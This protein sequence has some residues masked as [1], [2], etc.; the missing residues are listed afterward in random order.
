MYK[1]SIAKRVLALMGVLVVSSSVLAAE[2]RDLGDAS[3]V[4]VYKSTDEAELKLYIYNPSDHRADDARGAM[5]FFHGGGW[6]SGSPDQFAPHCRLLASQGMVAITAEYR[7]IQKHKTPAW[8]CVEDAKSAMRWVRSHA[9]ALGIDPERI[10]VG[11]GS[12][13]GHLA[14]CIGLDVPGFDSEGEDTSVRASADAMVLFNPALNIADIPKNYRWEGRNTDASPLQLVAKG[15]PPTIIFHGK[16]DQ[17]VNYDQAEAFEQ[18][19]KSAD[20]DCR[21]MGFE[22]AEHGFFNFGRG[23]GSAYTATTTA[24]VS[25]LSDL[26]FITPT[27]P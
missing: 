9:V 1:T 27:A 25:F 24:M 8:R 2:G 14:A 3:E 19:M 4:R 12:A 20:N 13:G 7:L 17:T 5:I 6:R 21:L 26:G 10:A 11:G 15:A 18:A 23:D 16:A 22:G